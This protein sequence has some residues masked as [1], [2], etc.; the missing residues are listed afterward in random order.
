MLL[1]L[2]VNAHYDTLLTE[3]DS[4]WDHLLSHQLVLVMGCLGTKGSSQGES[5]FNETL[6]DIESCVSFLFTV[7]CI[8][9][10]LPRG[11]SSANHASCFRVC[12]NSYRM[13]K[14]ADTWGCRLYMSTV[15]HSANVQSLCFHHVHSRAC[16]LFCQLLAA[17]YRF[18]HRSLAMTLLSTLFICTVVLRRCFGQVEKGALAAQA[19]D[20]RSPGEDIFAQMKSSTLPCCVQSVDGWRRGE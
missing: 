10:Q 11:G 6:G 15:E 5:P 4:R 1:M 19:G 14:A 3:D 20:V 12:W 9:R 8:Q 17:V 7:L 13:C 18:V 2:Q 16:Y